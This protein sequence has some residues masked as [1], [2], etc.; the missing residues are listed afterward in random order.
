MN[1]TDKNANG[2]FEIPRESSAITFEYFWNQYA[3]REQPFIIENVAANWVARKAWT[4]AYLQKRLS[5]EPLAKEA[6]LWYWLEKNALAEDYDIPEIV[7]T[8]LSHSDIFPRSQVMRIWVH[9]KGNLSSWHYDA[10]MISVF[11]VQVTGRKKW[12]LI[13]PET[14][15]CCYPFS[16]FA[17]LDGK[18][19]D[20]FHNKIYTH[21]ELNEGD[22][23]FL[24]PLWFHQVEACEAENVSLNWV[25]TKKE[26]Q[27][28]SSAFKRDYERYYFV[29]YF[30]RHKYP[31]YRTVAKQLN[32]LLP[33]YLRAKWT[34]QEIIKTSHNV[35]L[36][37]LALRMLKE[38]ASI[39]FVLR[40][41]NK[42]KPYRKTIKP[43]KR[44][45]R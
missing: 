28:T 30:S 35:N 37:V 27:I 2:Y 20:I 44:L 38:L 11:N 26:T 23:L 13:S 45:T 6:F 14:P 33:S 36:M 25:F 8:A 1:V 10:N 41:F 29:S 4:E 15:L 3:V 17:I 32:A 18:G 19:D 21:F 24:P 7:D 5:E 43:V 40:H 16:N 42:I 34:Y 39:A 31:V 12:S 22:M 9:E